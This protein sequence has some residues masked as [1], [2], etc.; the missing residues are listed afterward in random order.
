MDKKTI[1]IVVLLVLVLIFY[2]PILKFLGVVEEPEQPP[3]QPAIVDTTGSETRTVD[4]VFVT[5]PGTTTEPSDS[6]PETAQI[7]PAEIPE[8]DTMAVDTVVIETNMYTVT[9]ASKGG[10]PISILLKD[11]S[12]RDGTP[13]EMMPG[14][15]LGAPAATFQGGSFS[16]STKHFVADL[17][18]GT[19][20][21]TGSP[22]EIT[23]TYASPSG[24]QIVRK[25]T[26]YP[27]AHHFDLVVDVP[28]PQALGFER[29]YSLV[30]NSP[31]GVAEP[32]PKMDHD[33][34]EAV[35]L[36]A[37]SRETLTD[38][39]DGRLDQ[40]LS[41]T[42]SWAGVRNKYFTAVMIPKGRNADG[43]FARGTKEKIKSPEGDYDKKQVTVGLDMPFAMGGAIADTFTVFVGPLDYNLMT[44]YN[45]E[46]QDMIG[47]GT[48]WF[49]W[50]IKPFAIA[51][52][53]LLPRMYEIVGNYGV[54]IILFALLIKLV[55]LP[56]SMRSF[57]SMQAMKEIQPQMDAL[58]KKHSKDHQKLNQE[59]MKLYKKHGV[60]PMSGCLWIIPQMPLFFAM[61]SVFRSTIMLRAAP[62]VGFIDDLS[63]GAT[64]LTDPYMILVVIMVAAQFLSQKLTMATQ[65][66]QQKILM[67]IM[68]LFMGWI[69]H[70]FA[71][72]LVLYWACFS[73]FSLLDWLL[74]KR[75]S[76]VK[77][78]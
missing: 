54:V 57:K 56:L 69:F 32:N 38:F 52:I 36:M 40:S 46:L 65:Q 28:Q 4:T 72:G 63:R 59:I 53:W 62:F 6:S 17:P 43:V 9:M 39:D 2:W 78:A 75:N 77:T 22:M 24:G 33:A 60:N 48:G 76:V 5:Q 19:Y 41:G 3:E 26:F 15:S 44:E 50:I 21:A 23:Y 68:P 35:A 58:R 66:Q 49:G 70:T 29:R 31:L 16:T 12:L 37:D 20:D 55:T 7:T 61:F 27:D 45:V 73:I 1:P 25:Y 74:F 34:M 51:I 13:I 71:A 64:S 42:T 47:I 67:Y 14:D 30:W 18:P 11:Y 8:T 10:A